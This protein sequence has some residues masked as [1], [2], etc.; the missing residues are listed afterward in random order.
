MNLRKLVI[1][2]IASLSFN[3]TAG[4][5]AADFQQV[6]I[7]GP[8]DVDNQYS[9]VT[10][11][12]IKASDTLWAI[13]TKYQTNSNASIYQVMQAIFELNPASFEQNNINL[14][15]KGTILRLPSQ[16]YISWV[17]EKKGR[18]NVAVD[19][20]ILQ[21]DAQGQTL[22]RKDAR[23]QDK[24][25]SKTDLDET[26]AILE[27]KMGAIDE[28]QNRQFQAIRQQFSESIVGV[29]SILTEN[30][31]M[32]ER[33][34]SVNKDLA[35][36]RSQEVL[37]EQQMIQMGQ[38]IEELLNKSRREEQTALLAK[39]SSIFAWLS[40]PSILIIGSILPSLLLLGGLAYWLIKRKSKNEM[41]LDLLANKDEP[42]DTHVAT[43]MDDLSDALSE[44]LDEQ[45][46]FDNDI[47]QADVL[48]EELQASLN[49]TED[50]FDDL[51]DDMLVPDIDGAVENLDWDF[52]E[53]SDVIDQDDLDNLFEEEDDL[54]S[55]I[56]DGMDNVDLFNGEEMPSEADNA[57]VKE[58]PS[59]AV[60]N[61]TEELTPTDSLAEPAEPSQEVEGIIVKVEDQ[62]D[63]I[64][65]SIDELLV[66]PGPELPDGT[67]IL[68]TK[69][70]D[71]E[72]L[73]QLDK[74]INS[75]SEE[76]DNIISTLIDELEQVESMQDM[77]PDEESE[78]FSGETQDGLQQPD[79]PTESP[80]DIFIGSEGIDEINDDFSDNKVVDDSLAA[81]AG[82]DGIKGEKSQT[83]TVPLADKKLSQE[84]PAVADE[85]STSTD[86]Y[87]S[88]GTSVQ[89]DPLASVA[90]DADK[91]DNSPTDQGAEAEDELLPVEDKGAGEHLE[92][93]ERDSDTQTMT[94]QQDKISEAQPQ[95]TASQVVADA[96]E[97]D[98]LTEGLV[99]PA[100]MFDVEVNSTE[101]ELLAQALTEAEPDV[102][103]IDEQDHLA[104]QTA[105]ATEEEG[106]GDDLVEDTN[107]HNQ[108]TNERDNKAQDEEAGID[109]QSDKVET[110]EQLDSSLVREIQVDETDND[111]Q[112]DTA[113]T[114]DTQVEDADTESQANKA[115]TNDID[116]QDHTDS[117]Q[118]PELLSLKQ[119]D[120]GAIELEQEDEI[121]SCDQLDMALADFAND[122]ANEPLVESEQEAKNVPEQADRSIST[123]PDLDDI[124]SFSDFDDEELEKALQGFEW[125]EEPNA[126]S[127]P[128]ES[129]EQNHELDDVPGLGDWLNE[130]DED[131][132]AL[133]AELENA[134]FDDLLKNIDDDDAQEDLDPAVDIE[135]LLSDND[136]NGNDANTEEN[137]GDFLDVETLLNE[138][139]DTQAN[140]L[141]DKD[142]DLKLAFGKFSST[143]DDVDTV[144][145]DSDSGLGAKLDLAHA[146]IEIGEIESAKELLTEIIE[147]GHPLHSEEA[148]LVLGNL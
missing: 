98:T 56:D 65:V 69:F 13:A 38:S 119:N 137:D 110:D 7:K 24:L 106:L 136:G 144:D 113:L 31:K 2:L 148:K 111:E 90:A 83:N 81:D 101:D 20:Q 124:G 96:D 140:S 112:I 117:E 47:T 84:R 26:K 91:R 37:K 57:K 34:D 43:E 95:Q 3:L 88:D 64:E 22:V 27:Q 108:V 147:H 100:A 50:E 118:H 130:A 68:S 12:P 9:G 145:V 45:P 16:R 21:S 146:Y 99:A 23:S 61:S 128:F 17:N 6:L 94:A 103:G 123:L 11:G 134:N 39:Q 116:V 79:K 59:S 46:L 86:Q 62:E 92:Q 53:G 42:V 44:E 66:Q 14:L 82:Q 52:E 29:Q 48:G 102:P 89:V 80:S 109:A 30:Q 131:D 120:C 93:D 121:E 141:S 49:D 115:D 71:E 72:I 1:L 133:L 19:E 32:F 139:L 127:T 40:K 4:A 74:Q 135:A 142:F 78:S 28:E 18:D 10:Y 122:E 97:V 76:L 8:K 107:S 36:M 58:K 33:L 132:K 126:P 60:D 129:P 143:T 51:G 55:Q 5:F 41:D 63:K 54:L 138:S 87:S 75:Q 104:N 114:G 35:S 105:M 25:A 85:Q 77:L 67:D 70:I 125:D 73:Q 15:V